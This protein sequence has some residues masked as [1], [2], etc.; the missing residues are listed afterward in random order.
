[1]ARSFAKGT[2]GKAV[3]FDDIPYA[4]LQNEEALN[5]LLKLFQI[6]FDSGKIPSDWR[7]AIIVPIPKSTTDDPRLPLNY[8]AIKFAISHSKI[9][10]FNI[11]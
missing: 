9:I 2:V 1:M 8:R 6:C 4:V 3:G 10:Q 11:K 7:K 5:V